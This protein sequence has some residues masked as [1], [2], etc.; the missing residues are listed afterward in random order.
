MLL[1]IQSKAMTVPSSLIPDGPAFRQI[2]DAVSDGIFIY[3]GKGTLLAC[4]QRGREMFGRSEDQLLGRNAGEIAT[5]S[6]LQ[7]HVS[8]VLAGR[9]FAEIR[10]NASIE[11]FSRPGYLVFESGQRVFYTGTYVRGND[12]SLRYAI[13]TLRDATD[14]NEARRKIEELEKLTDLYR[15]Q[16]QSLNAQL[17]GHELVA[18][19]AAMQEVLKRAFR[20][21]SM[22]E[23]LLIT[24][25]TGVG[26]SLLAR[27][28]HLTSAR[29]QKAFI[30]VNCASLQ[31]QLAE[32]ELFGYREGA[33]TGASRHGH[34]G[35]F[36]AAS[37][38]TLF[39][40]EIG[41]MP[42]SIQAKLLTAIE[43]K[44]VRRVGGE[45]Q[46]SVDVRILFATNQVPELLI[47]K[48]LLREDFY[49]RLAVNRIEIPPLRSRTED[50]PSLIEQALREHNNKY[51]TRKSFHQNLVSQL[52]TLRLPGNV[53]EL[54]AIVGQIASEVDD[55]T[56]VISPEMVHAEL[57]VGME[58]P[59]ALDRL[60][61][62]AGAV[63]YEGEEAMLRRLCAENHGDIRAIAC[64]LGIHRTTVLRKL[65]RYTIAYCRKPW[66]RRTA[67]RTKS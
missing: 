7:E 12:G 58:R 27:Y 17:L 40:D 51:G 32:A 54:K 37:G 39:L 14:L 53:R 11:D 22:D 41:E 24:G 4:N 10:G 46:V 42:L 13:F 63:G 56:T 47:E 20:F 9:T 21:A 29:A 43:E 67:S 15:T 59:L 35:L 3:D 23:N 5:L 25:E 61:P 30:S 57:P 52:Q 31:E 34:K 36:E 26:K 16:L 19:S 33:F 66:E 28:I 44:S 55:D 38:G 65:R 49:Y 48:H 64:V 8:S 60:G 18:V 50:I 1:S 45:A 6:G 62:G 2:L